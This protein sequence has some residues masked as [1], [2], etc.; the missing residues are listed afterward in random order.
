MRS[1]AKPPSDDLAEDLRE[2]VE[3]AASG[4]QPDIELV[5][6]VQAH[7]GQLIANHR[8]SLSILERLQTHAGQVV[9]HLKAKSRNSRIIPFERIPPSP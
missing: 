6:A 7:I 9:E 5:E 2:L 1:R 8:Q 4:D 3:R